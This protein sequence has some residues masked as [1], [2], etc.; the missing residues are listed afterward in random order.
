[1]SLPRDSPTVPFGVWV[2]DEG[3]MWHRG[4][5]SSSG[6]RGLAQCRRE[7]GPLTG[8]PARRFAPGE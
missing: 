5:R 1:M 3:T 6:V 2:M 4:Q 8:I 7:A